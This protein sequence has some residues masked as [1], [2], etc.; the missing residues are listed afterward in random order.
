MY[1]T[2]NTPHLQLM[3]NIAGNFLISSR[4]CQLRN[5]IFDPNNFCI[6]VNLSNIDTVLDYIFDDQNTFVRYN[7]RT[8]K[9]KSGIKKNILS[10]LN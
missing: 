9:T 5:Y 3:K 4:V 6:Y 7:K 10:L 2:K 8:Y 1:N